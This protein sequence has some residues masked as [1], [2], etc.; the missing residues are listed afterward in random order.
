MSDIIVF[1]KYVSFKFRFGGAA[2][3]QTPHSS[4]PLG[5]PLTLSDSGHGNPL[6]FLSF[7]IRKFL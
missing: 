6:N 1:T 2:A 4:T 5:T 7:Q 3:P